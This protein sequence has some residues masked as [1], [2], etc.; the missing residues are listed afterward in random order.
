MSGV[1]TNS[2]I[3]DFKVDD[4]IEV[5]LVRM[6]STVDGSTVVIGFAFVLLLVPTDVVGSTVVVTSG[7]EDFKVVENSSVVA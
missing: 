2:G 7:V 4:S 5:A 6:W 3:K 1:A